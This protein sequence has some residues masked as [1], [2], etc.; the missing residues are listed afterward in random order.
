MDNKEEKLLL[1]GFSDQIFSA[2]QRNIPLERRQSLLIKLGIDTVLNVLPKLIVTIIIAVL[3]HELIPVVIFVVSFLLLR[4]FAYG[5]HL[6]SDLVCTI[7]TIIVFT[8]VPYFIH[9]TGGMPVF[10]RILSSIMMIIGIGIL[11]PADTRKNPITSRFRKKQL[12]KRAILVSVFLSS[13]QL[14]ISNFTGTVVAVAMFTA[15]LLL[16]P[17][18]GGKSNER[19]II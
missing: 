5:R 6:Q 1:G 8:G 17:L 10:G 16:I 4:G 2:I 7:L 14:V 3:L 11:A 15:L 18:R 13:L 19:T 9:F 12:K